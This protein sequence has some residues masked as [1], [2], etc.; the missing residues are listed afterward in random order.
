MGIEFQYPT[1]DAA[2]QAQAKSKFDKVAK[3]KIDKALILLKIS[4]AALP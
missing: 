4:I 1:G 3:L 2:I